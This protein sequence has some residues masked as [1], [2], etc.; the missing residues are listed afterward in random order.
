LEIS[1][2]KDS[3]NLDPIYKDWTQNNRDFQTKN[4]E[5][6]NEKELKRERKKRGMKDLRES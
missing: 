3:I 4:L 2:I 5:R 1:T 6:R